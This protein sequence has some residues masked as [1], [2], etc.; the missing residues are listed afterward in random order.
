MGL[1]DQFFYGGMQE[2]QGDP[3]GALLSELLKLQQPQA[4]AP[5]LP[6]GHVMPQAQAQAPPAPNFLDRLS[7]MSRGYG[8]GGLVGGISDAI[9]LG[10][11]RG[12]R[13]QAQQRNATFE[14]LVPKVGEQAAR[15]AMGNPELLKQ[16]LKTVP[17]ARSSEYS[18]NPLYGVDKDGNTV[19]LQAGDQ[20]DVVQSRMPEGVTLNAKPQQHDLGDRIGIFD[21]ATRTYTQFMPKGIAEKAR[22]EEAGTAQGKAQV[23]L[24]QVEAAAARMFKQIAG[25]ENDP[26]LGSVTGWQASFPTVFAK[27][28]DTEERI[29]QLSG[30]AFLQAFESLKGGGQIT[31]PEGEKATA[32]LARLQNLKQSD[33]GF[34][35]AL[36]DFKAEVQALVELARKKA[37]G[38][39]APEQAASGGWSGLRRLD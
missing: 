37:G 5:P 30:G 31:Q 32:A 12:E 3:Q 33:A 38:G 4:Q 18:K 36:A 26:N 27:S 24:P 6:T 28:V 13:A 39:A 10:D 25:V 34:K 8:E 21:P 2:Q 11:S 20:G 15:A 19:L 22:Q 14:Y 9:N 17:G 23:I 35:Q 16:V 7:A 1:L 29:K